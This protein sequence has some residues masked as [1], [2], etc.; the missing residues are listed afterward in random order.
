MLRHNSHYADSHRVGLR[1][2]C[3][4]KVNTAISQCHQEGR[5]AREAVEFGDHE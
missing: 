4:D 3:G 1:Q 2:V 5:V